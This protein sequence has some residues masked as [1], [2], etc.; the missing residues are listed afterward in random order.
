MANTIQVDANTSTHKSAGADMK[1]G[2]EN[3]IQEFF[4]E[5]FVDKGRKKLCVVLTGRFQPFHNG[6]KL[7]YQMIERMF[8]RDNIWILMNFSADY[9]INP[10][11]FDA[12]KQLM[13]KSGININESHIRPKKHI[14]I[15]PYQIA[16]DI[17]IA[18]RMDE[19]VF[20]CV[21]SEADSDL[22]KYK[23]RETY[24]QPWPGGE[25]YQ[26][27]TEQ[28][29]QFTDKLPSMKNY[30]FRLLVN[31][32]GNEL[33]YDFKSE[34]KE[35]NVKK[36]ALIQ[37]GIHEIKNSLA[38]NDM[39]DLKDKLPYDPNL[40]KEM[41]DYYFNDKSDD[42]IEKEKELKQE[43]LKF[44]E[45]GEFKNYIIS[46]TDQGDYQSK[47]IKAKNKDDATT[48]A[49]NFLNGENFNIEEI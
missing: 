49:E 40:L 13:M 42:Q 36:Q 26:A 5:R 4:K 45:D 30:G 15:N 44:K 43:Y 41:E 9:P 29:E 22:V 28:I 8:G 1:T 34:K 20:V 48:Q 47:E 33:I 35:L 24:F 7:A 32:F 21:V 17:G 39:S 18:D 23:A 6:H 2:L 11:P 3:F 14:G 25:L 27:N 12:R 37:I 16:K 38:T 31:S 10:L 46:W 19:Y